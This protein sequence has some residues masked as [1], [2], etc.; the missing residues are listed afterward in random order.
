MTAWDQI[1]EYTHHAVNSCAGGSALQV[2]YSIV[3]VLL[4]LPLC[5]TVRVLLCCVPRLSTLLHYGIPK[6]RPYSPTKITSNSCQPWTALRPLDSTQ[7]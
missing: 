7:C 5:F 4:Y 6:D 3:C 2:R 1:G